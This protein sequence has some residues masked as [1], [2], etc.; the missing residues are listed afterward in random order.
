VPRGVLVPA[1][2]PLA[3]R[4]EVS[5]E[6][7]VDYEFF[8]APDEHGTPETRDLWVPRVTPSGRPLRRTAGDVLTMTGQSEIV[9][10]DVLTLVAR[11]CGL[12]LTVVSLL[13]NVP[14]PDLKIV[15]ISDMPPMAIVPVWSSTAE[16][17]L[18]RPFVDALAGFRRRN[19]ATPFVS[20]P[21]PPPRARA[22]RRFASP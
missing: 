12:H 1:G 18:I 2:H 5:L 22:S 11:G 16:N 20:P 3:A 4:P 6:D 8:W 10:D 13:D 7:L 17:P 14:F 9:V 21:E 15:P 19:E